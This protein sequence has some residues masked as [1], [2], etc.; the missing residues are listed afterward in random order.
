MAV[1]CSQWIVC[2]PAWNGSGTGRSTQSLDVIVSRRAKIAVLAFVAVVVITALCWRWY[3][4]TY[5]DLCLAAGGSV[6]DGACLGSRTHM[7]EKQSLWS[8]IGLGIVVP[9]VIMLLGLGITQALSREN[10]R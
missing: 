2:S 1:P 4:M 6:A 10:R 8:F 5:L 9:A 3:E 7:P